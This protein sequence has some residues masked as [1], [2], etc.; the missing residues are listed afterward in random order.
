MLEQIYW[1][2][3]IVVPMV[4]I[5]GLFIQYRK[6]K[7]PENRQNAT[8]SGQHNTIN[9]ASEIRINEHKDGQ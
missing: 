5:V 3:G 6:K 9:Q 2:A 8:I 7:S 4:A 1:I